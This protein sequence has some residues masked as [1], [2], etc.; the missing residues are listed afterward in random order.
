MEFSLIPTNESEGNFYAKDT[1]GLNILHTTYRNKL[2]AK[3]Y[4]EFLVMNFNFMILFLSLRDIL[5]ILIYNNYYFEQIFLVVKG[6]D[7]R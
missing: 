5:S 3:Y 7:F 4:Y 1:L 2:L 6:V